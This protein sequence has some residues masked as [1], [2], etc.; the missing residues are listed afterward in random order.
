[1]NVRDLFLMQH[2]AVHSKAVG[3]NAASTA[4]RTFGGLVSPLGQRPRVSHI[5]DGEHLVGHGLAGGQRVGVGED[6]RCT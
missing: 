2:G 6:Q 4:E 3:G 1:M 5:D